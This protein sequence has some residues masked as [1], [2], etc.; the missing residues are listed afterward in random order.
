MKKLYLILGILL[1]IAGILALAWGGLSCFAYKN[2]L[3][4]SAE[5]YERLRLQMVRFLSGGAVLTVLGAAA[6]VLSRI[7]KP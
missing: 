2:T 5:L 4:G 7:R 3:D 6:I 1:L